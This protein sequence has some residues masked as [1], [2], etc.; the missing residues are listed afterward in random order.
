MTD[1]VVEAVREMLLQRSRIGL[2]KYGRGLDRFEGGERDILQHMLEEMLDGANY[3]M[4]RI[5]MI[6]GE[7]G[8]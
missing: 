4:T 6:D 5:M 2:A 7:V 3:I 1:A 8:K